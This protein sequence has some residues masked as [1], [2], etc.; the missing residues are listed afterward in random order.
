MG[1]RRRRATGVVLVALF[2]AAG[3]GLAWRLVPAI[4]PY[5]AA[6][7]VCAALLRGDYDA[8]YRQLGPAP[9]AQIS[10]ATFAA[11]ERLADQQAGRVTQCDASLFGISWQGTTAVAQVTERRAG[12]ATVAL[13]LRLAGTPLRLVALPDAAALPYAVAAAWCAALTA[14]DYPA[15]YALLAPALTTALPEARFAAF[16]R[17]ADQNG[18]PVTACAVSQLALD[19]AGQRATAT[20]AQT[21]QSDTAPASRPLSIARQATGIWQIATLPPL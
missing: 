6:Q 20:I 2:L 1:Q 11:A 8:V 12:G 7:A 19:A 4:G 9:Q 14:Q 16:A 18:G 15:A 17:L 3:G 10:A 5:Q 13:S 21:R